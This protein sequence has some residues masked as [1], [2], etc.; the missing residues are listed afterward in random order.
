MKNA[1]MDLGIF[2]GLP[3]I[4]M[5]TYPEM[6]LLNQMVVSSLFLEETPHCCHKNQSNLY[7]HQQWHSSPHHFDDRCE[8]ISHAVLIWVSLIIS[9]VG[10]FSHTY[11]VFYVFF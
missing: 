4:S 1:T 5:A 8:G 9:D 6:T 11:H 2:R 3:H 7:A 10:Y